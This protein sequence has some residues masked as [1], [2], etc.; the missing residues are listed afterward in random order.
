MPEPSF[1]EIKDLP[2]C[3]PG[4][5]SATVLAYSG[6]VR[7]MYETRDSP[8]PDSDS[9]A[10]I[11][12][13]DCGP[14]HGGGPNDE[15]V[16]NHRLYKHG[17]LGYSIQEVLNSPWLREQNALKHRDGNPDTPLARRRHFILALKETL[18]ECAADGYSL[19]GEFNSSEAAYRALCGLDEPSR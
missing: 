1:V 5:S 2:T 12:F 4:T 10:V 11:R 16:H 9:W 18:F 8:W 15:A 13:H 3:C 17:L 6:T 19:V 14:Y 7:L